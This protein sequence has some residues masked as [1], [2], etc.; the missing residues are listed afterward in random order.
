MSKSSSAA[1]ES[2]ADVRGVGNVKAATAECLRSPRVVDDP[3]SAEGSLLGL[4][5]A[6]GDDAAA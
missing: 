2:D 4:A 3:Y 6:E 5:V 1:R